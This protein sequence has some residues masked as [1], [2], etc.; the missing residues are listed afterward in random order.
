MA[1]SE[2]D[3]IGARYSYKWRNAKR[4]LPGLHLIYHQVILVYKLIETEVLGG[5]VEVVVT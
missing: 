5:L 2:Y 3:V 4:S 1:G